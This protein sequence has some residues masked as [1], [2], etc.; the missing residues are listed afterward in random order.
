MG[1]IIS[2]FV[3]IVFI[4]AGNNI[5][6]LVNV[7]WAGLVCDVVGG[8]L[9]ILGAKLFIDSR[10]EDM[11][12]RLEIINYLRDIAEKVMTFSQAENIKKQIDVLCENQNS[13][14]DT[15]VGL[16]RHLVEIEE[17]YQQNA[18]KNSDGERNAKLI[19]SSLSELKN[20]IETLLGNMSN[21]VSSQLE[22]QVCEMQAVNQ[23]IKDKGDIIYKA[24]KTETEH[25]D[26]VAGKVELFN[27]LPIEILE[28]ADELIDKI[29]KY[30][31]DSS[32]KFEQLLDDLYESD[33][34][35]TD[36]SNKILN[37]IRDSNVENNEQIATQIGKLGEEYLQFQKIINSIVNQ[38]TLM[39]EKDYEIMKGFI[40]G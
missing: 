12:K 30:I 27:K 22:K 39:S 4:A 40:N 19:L 15:L 25:I 6:S 28:S 26:N 36:R 33:K 32:N 3:G 8:G 29:N 14:R 21:Q 34:K 2:F 17:R 35:R 23:S 10:K 31:E 11:K 13:F 7:E 9:M 24:S 18:Y 16:D 1:T 37:E 38:M 20:G 5:S